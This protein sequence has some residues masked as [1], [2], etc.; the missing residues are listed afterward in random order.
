MRATVIRTALVAVLICAGITAQTQ[1]Y[2]CD[3]DQFTLNRI[4]ADGMN[5]TTIA[6][7][8][9]GIDDVVVDQVNGYVFWTNRL[10]RTI[11]R[12]DLD[13]NNHMVIH[14][15]ATTPSGIAIRAINQF[16]YF[17]EIGGGVYRIKYDGMG[18]TTI[19]TTAA[20]CYGVTLD[21]E[22]FNVYW[23]ERDAGRIW[24]VDQDGLGTPTMIVDNP[25]AIGVVKMAVDPISRRIFW[26][27]DHTTG[28]DGVWR[29]DLD[30]LNSNLVQINT[31][32]RVANVSIDFSGF[33]YWTSYDTNTLKRAE[34]DGSDVVTVHTSATPTTSEFY[35]VDVIE[36]CSATPIEYGPCMV[37]GFTL[38]WI[39]GLPG[40][41]TQG[42]LAATGGLAGST[43]IVLG[44]TCPDDTED[45]GVPILVDLSA[46]TLIG[47]SFMWDAMGNWSIPLRIDVPQI[48][49][50][51]YYTQVF[52]NPAGG[53]I[54][55]TNGVAVRFCAL[56]N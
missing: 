19:A 24:C 17:T 25:A 7:V 43:G 14:T 36:D 22:C 12:A 41:E 6:T 33:I 52:G 20:Q 51:I 55:S 32:L 9:L 28:N 56:P 4:D 34:L 23:S 38:G 45:S 15:A 5:L 47:S 54:G 1:I 48:A 18:L 35:G 21:R 16:I 13:G 3:Q 30:G 10:T 40:T 50:Y 11:N 2:F 39:P 31:D 29:A 53:G 49:D 42:T 8:Q 44:A 46:P 37:A 26:G 27:N